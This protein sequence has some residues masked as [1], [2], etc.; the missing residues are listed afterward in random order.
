MKKKIV[1]LSGAGLDA[2]SGI[3]TF[4]S[5]TDALW[6]NHKITDVC[7]ATAWNK[8]PTLVN[9]FY[10]IRRIEVLNASPNKAHIDLAQAEE[11]YD[12]THITTNVSDLLERAG[13]TSVLHLHGHLL[14]ART[15]REGVGS[16]PDYLVEPFIVP[17]G[18]EGIKPM[19]EASDGHLLRPHVVFFNETVPN[20]PNATEIIKT[21]DVLIVVGTSLSVYPAASLVWDVKD[22]CKVFYVDPTEDSDVA[23][24]FPCQHIKAPATSGISKVLNI[25]AEGNFNVNKETKT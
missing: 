18:Q 22:G 3:A 12:I 25:L 2:E 5:G 15:S 21:A 23:L 13:C 6:D 11:L 16:L 17:V 1:V 7:T 4:R 24:S 14:K 9:D 10:N 20:L 19:Q 8:D